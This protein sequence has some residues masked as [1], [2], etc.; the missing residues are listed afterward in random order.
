MHLLVH[1]ATVTGALM[2]DELDA[3]FDF[4]LQ[5]GIGLLGRDEYGRTPLIRAV[6]PFILIR[7]TSF[8]MQFLDCRKL[9]GG[10]AHPHARQCNA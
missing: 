2:T 10:G 3:M 9:P 8:S 1:V 7:S 6:R 5:H 4:F